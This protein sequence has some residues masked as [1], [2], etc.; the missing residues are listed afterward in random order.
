[1]AKRTVIKVGGAELREGDQ[2]G[3]LVDTLCQASQ[4]SELIVVHGG[5]P[6]I[7]GLQQRLGLEPCFVDGLRVT[8]DDCL[9]VA[10]MVLSGAV[11]K[12]LAARLVSCQVRAI[13]IS[14][15][16]G[17]LLRA[18]RLEH[19]GGDLGRVGEITD[20]ETGCLEDL[21]SAGFTPLVSP[22][23]LG[24]D[25]RPFNVNADHA[26]L[27]IAQAM[28]ADE[29][30]FLTNVPGVLGDGGIIGELTAEGA[31]ALI[32][33]GVVSGGMI[34]KVRSAIEAVSAGVG[35]VRITDMAGLYAGK[36][37]RVVA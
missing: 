31:E 27:A 11:N 19:P 7:A 37:T 13:G 3:R 1:M 36:G 21:L 28:R 23:S 22:I 9:S 5:G 29:L 10:E 26:A 14:G 8:D 16:D 20:V 32:D 35:A 4:R 15:V 33:A 34:P 18:R 24:D 12:R 17:G 6:E 30:V 25:G 2:I